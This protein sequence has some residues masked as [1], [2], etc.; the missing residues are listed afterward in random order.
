LA[1]GSR[2]L[3][4]FSSIVTARVLLQLLILLLD[5]G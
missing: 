2:L 3:L 4:L 5:T 1:L